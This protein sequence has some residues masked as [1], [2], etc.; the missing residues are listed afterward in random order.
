[1]CSSCGSIHY[2]LKVLNIGTY[3]L[4]NYSSS[5]QQTASD[6]LLSNS[7]RDIVIHG[8]TLYIADPRGGEIIIFCKVA[9]TTEVSKC[10]LFILFIE[11]CVSIPIVENDLAVLQKT[12][13]M[14][15]ETIKVLKVDEFP[16]KQRSSNKTNKSKYSVAL[17]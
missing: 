1:M 10:C 11:Y 12:Q 6:I 2:I 14:E 16:K 8:D 5:R 3:G 7:V 13:K 9:K 17:G 4:S 15:K